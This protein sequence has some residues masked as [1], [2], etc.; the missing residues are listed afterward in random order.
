MS[1]QTTAN[2][3]TPFFYDDA[4]KNNQG[5]PT[6]PACQRTWVYNLEQ[7]INAAITLCSN[8]LT[9]MKDSGPKRETMH[10]LYERL[11]HL[12]GAHEP[13]HS[14]P[15]FAQAIATPLREAQQLTESWYLGCLNPESPERSRTQV[16][17]TA[18]AVS[19]L[20]KSL[21]AL[22][23]VDED[24]HRVIDL[25]ATSEPF[26]QRFNMSRKPYQVFD[27]PPEIFRSRRRS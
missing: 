24:G 27:T 20:R 18:E 21:N 26:L 19:D 15:G 12:S 14:L 10:A 5:A 6:N 23:A 25:K 2:R 22:V 4:F 17:P 8:L 11:V 9:E 13:H 3:T 7:G 1:A 16:C